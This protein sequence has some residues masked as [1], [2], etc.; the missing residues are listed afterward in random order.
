VR[1]SS[2]LTSRSSAPGSPPPG[3]S[4]RPARRRSA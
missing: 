1:T 2:R 3:S 4:R